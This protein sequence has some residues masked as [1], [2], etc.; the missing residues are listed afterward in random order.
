M[1]IFIVEGGYSETQDGFVIYYKLKRRSVHLT[2]YSRN[3][4]V[5]AHIK[6]S[7]IGDERIWECRKT[8]EEVN[9]TIVQWMN[10]SIKKYHGNRKYLILRGELLAL[11][12]EIS[13]TD[14]SA[15]EIIFDL[16]RIARGLIFYRKELE[17]SGLRIRLRDGISLPTPGFIFSKTQ[18]YLCVPIDQ[19]RMFVANTDF[20]KNIF[21]MLP[22]GKGIA[23]Y[24]RYLEKQKILDR[25]AII[26]DPQKG[27]ALR[28]FESSI[29]SSIF[30]F[31]INS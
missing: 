21:G 2:C 4:M 14:Y 12:T 1:T 16:G 25:K 6:D 31:G 19:H 24:F 10:R 29:V 22:F 26:N 13:K 9:E 17:R 23:E 3:G 28:S 27:K 11:L 18:S 15:N 7:L 5:D 30:D 20:R 8:V